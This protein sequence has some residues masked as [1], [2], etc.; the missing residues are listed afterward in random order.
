MGGNS[1]LNLFLLAHNVL[2]EM[3]AVY[4]VSESSGRSLLCLLSI[5]NIRVWPA[6]LSI[7]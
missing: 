6:A 5:Q 7:L 4:S 1:L 2:N 3:I